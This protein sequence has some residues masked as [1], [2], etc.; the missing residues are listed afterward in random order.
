[1]KPYQRI[2][3]EGFTIPELARLA[4]QHAVGIE[5]DAA[6]R[7]SKGPVF[8]GRL[9]AYEVQPGLIATASDVTY[10]SDQELCSRSEPS[11]MFGV[12]LN[13]ERES[14]EVGGY[15][16][17]TRELEKPALLG[18]SERTSFKLRGEKG[19]RTAAA[20]FLIKPSFF[21]RFGENIAD[22][23]LAALK[24][25]VSGKFRYETMARSPRLLE[26][27]R[28]LLEHPYGGQLG[29][30]FLESNTLS[31]VIEVAEQLKQERKMVALIGRR[32]YDRVMEARD[33][34][35]TNLIDPPKTLELARRVGVNLTTLQ[36]NFKTV[37]GV[38]IFG[39]V[40]TQRLMMARVLL[41][42]HNLAVAEA[43]YRVGFASPA[44][45]TAAYRRYFG[46]P[47]GLEVRAAG[48]EE[49]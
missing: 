47:P 49:K 25:F 3:K 2:S 9:L 8:S 22:D 7:H 13:G 12:L 35:D 6:A 46:H 16:E 31:L 5:L 27:S 34:L 48:K 41:R 15:G 21:D 42:D 37:L 40:R 33:I 32:H 19:Q 20:G 38:T 10:L 18:F 39:Y 29:Q 24:E 11:L 36:A 30:L 17:I 4:T 45:F 23:G 26:L 43:G 44:A 28:Y 14:M 1:M